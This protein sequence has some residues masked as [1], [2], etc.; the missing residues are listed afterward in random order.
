MLTYFFTSIHLYIN[1]AKYAITVDIEAAYSPI[2][3][4]KAIFTT[5][6]IIAAIIDVFAISFASW[7]FPTPLSPTRTIL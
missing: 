4:I 1:I 2:G 5:I 6:L 7:V 3:F